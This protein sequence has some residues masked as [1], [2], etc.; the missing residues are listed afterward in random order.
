MTKRE[1]LQEVLDTLGDDEIVTMWN[2]ICDN[3]GNYEDRLYETSELD[4]L[5]RGKTPLEIIEL[6]QD[7]DIDA[8]YINDGIYGLETHYDIYDVVDDDDILDYIE[9]EELAFGNFEIEEIL[10]GE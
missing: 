2:E 1:R 7:I 8:P 10:F 6:C 9:E 4:E 3:Y 5:L